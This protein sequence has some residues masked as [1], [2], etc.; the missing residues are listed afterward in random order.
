VLPGFAKP[1]G[2]VSLFIP[3]GDAG[4]IKHAHASAEDEPWIAQQ[5]CPKQHHHRAGKLH[6]IGAIPIYAAGDQ[7]LGWIVR[8][9]CAETAL[10]K[11]GNRV[12]TRNGEKKYQLD[13]RLAEETW[14]VNERL[15]DGTCVGGGAQGEDNFREK[16]QE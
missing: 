5:R 12:N 14:C 10:G 6:R 4:R 8:N 3:V 9:R 13:R 11:L 15:P 1:R 7:A 16:K 2:Q